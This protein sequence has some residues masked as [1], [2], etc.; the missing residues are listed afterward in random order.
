MYTKNTALLI[1]L[2][3]HNLHTGTVTGPGMTARG[4]HNSL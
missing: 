4:A 3:A 2:I 1:H